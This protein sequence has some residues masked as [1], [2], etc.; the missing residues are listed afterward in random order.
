LKA[1]DGVDSLNGVNILVTGGAGFIGSHLCARLL[2][3][4]GRVICADNLLTGT[5]RN[6]EALRDEPNFVFLLHDVTEPL[7]L[8]VDVIFHL[9]S[10]ASP[11]GYWTYPFETIRV[12]SEG[13]HRLL[14]LARRRGARFLLSSTSEAYGDPERHPQV[15]TYWGNV[16]PVGVR[17]CYDESKRLG[18]TITM[19]FHRRYAADARIVRIFNTYGPHNQLDDGRMVPNFITQA[20]QGQPVTVHGTG[21][22]TRSICYVDDMVEGLMRTMFTPNTAGQVYN[23]G[24]PEEHSVLDWARTI[25]RLCGSASPI[26][27]EPKREDDPERRRP[28]TDKVRDALGWQPRIAPQEGL[29]RTIVWARKELERQAPCLTERGFDRRA[30]RAG[31]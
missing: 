14:E 5:E 2:R 23:L 25:I 17:A 22:Q 20:L 11:I 18:E 24:N 21:M 29:A 16:N 9:A 1:L 7:D 3:A 8:D 28:N 10:P 19:E 26:V 31:P 15:E 30:V 27:Y 4:G 6:L 12:N 13:T